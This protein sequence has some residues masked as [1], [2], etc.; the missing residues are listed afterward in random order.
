MIILKD[1][2]QLLFNKQNHQKLILIVIY[3]IS[4]EHF[5]DIFLANSLIGNWN[6]YT[7]T[8]EKITE[9]INITI[10]KKTIFSRHQ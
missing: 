8:I 4:L 6:K 9:R 5:L 1:I 3:Y 7:I 10:L 2:N